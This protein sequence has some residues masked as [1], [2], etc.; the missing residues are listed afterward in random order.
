MIDLSEDTT[1]ESE[2]EKAEVAEAP[3][4]KRVKYDTRS[5]TPFNTR[6]INDENTNSKV[7][8][9]KPPIIHESSDEED[10]AES[11]SSS[12]SSSGEAENVS[13]TLIQKPAKYSSSGQATVNDKAVNASSQGTYG[14]GTTDQ[15]FELSDD[16]SED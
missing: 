11:R 14:K 3:A 1:D 9:P 2:E 13:A 12:S 5:A 4:R 8:V 7:V 15:P 6:T 10:E 16:D